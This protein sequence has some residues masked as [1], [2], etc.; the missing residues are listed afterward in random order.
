MSLVWIGINDDVVCLCVFGWRSLDD[1]ILSLVFE[2]KQNSS[3][4]KQ[5]HVFISWLNISKTSGWI[6]NQTNGKR[7]RERESWSPSSSCFF[8]ETA[9][10]SQLCQNPFTP[11][12]SIIE[13]HECSCEATLLKTEPTIEWNQ[14]GWTDGS[15]KRKPNPKTICRTN[16]WVQR[17]RSYRNTNHTKEEQILALGLF[18]FYFFILFQGPFF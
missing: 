5:K 12:S 7:E 14:R 9:E 8:V 10:G 11:F 4:W 3:W 16:H 2:T 6:D 17:L 1:V 15:D 13:E 18:G